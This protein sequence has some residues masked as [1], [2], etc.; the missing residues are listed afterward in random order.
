MKLH[1]RGLSIVLLLA[2]F[3]S[4]YLA[5]PCKVQAASK[6]ALSKNTVSV[7]KGKTVTIK[8]RN[9]K[10]RVK[11]SS[12]NKKIAYVKKKTGK[13]RQKA[14][15][16]AKKKG[17]CYI[18]AKI[19][20]KT[21]KCKVTVKNKGD[22]TVTPVFP[23]DE[24]TGLEDRVIRTRNLS[25]SSKDLTSGMKSYPPAYS[26]PD[27]AFIN[28]T[29]SFSFNLFKETVKSERKTSAVTNILISP[30]SVMTALAMTENGAAGN[31]L[32]EMEYVLGGGISAS[33]IPCARFNTYLSGLNRKLMGSDAFIYNVANSIWAR[34]NM[35]SPKTSFLQANK[36][37]HD[38]EY[39]V[40]PFNDQTSADM[41]SWVFNKS[42]NMIDNIIGKLSEDSRMVLINTVAFEGVWAKQFEESRMKRED[43]T[44]GSGAKQSAMML[45]DTGDY[46]YFT[47]NSGQAF[48]KS[49][50]IGK[51][52]GKIAFVGILPPKGESIDHFI[53]GLNGSSFISAWNSRKNAVINLSL[54]EFSY[55]YS[56]EMADSLNELGIREAFTDDAD[57]SNMAIPA[58]ETP[59]LKISKVLHK[60]HIEVYAKGTKA[61]AATA[62]VME[63]AGAA[64]GTDIIELKFDRPF[65]YALVDADSGIPLFIGEVV[66]V[67]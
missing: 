24:G 42:R 35:V 13:K 25:N 18:K 15:I 30:D 3:I 28:G 55:D 63:K 7:T 26:A 41:N 19:G 50:R 17:T 53:A 39:F 38:A 48:V 58:P 20:K 8:V 44:S 64:F 49:Y 9:A 65:V 51:K 62:V 21:L 14:V 1:K 47:V 23:D 22:V 67:G 59:G 33:G 27:A 54:P 45:K 43:F 37:Y 61:A 52:A 46:Q 10:K 2:V 16:K 11:W 56:T 34:E 66:S 12:T 60:T 29:S 5:V 40:A 4:V 36:N 32:S 57:F 31:T 6:P